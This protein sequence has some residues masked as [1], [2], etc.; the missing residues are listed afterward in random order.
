MLQ[1]RDILSIGLVQNIGQ[2]NIVHQNFGAGVGMN[3]RLTSILHLTSSVGYY[4]QRVDGG[5]FDRNR[6]QATVGL[7]FSPGERPLSIF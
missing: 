3:Y 1:L 4:I 6:F 2:V 5:N 7:S